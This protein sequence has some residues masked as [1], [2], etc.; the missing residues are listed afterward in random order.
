MQ[1]TLKSCKDRGGILFHRVF[2]VVSVAGGM[3]SGC[4]LLGKHQKSGSSTG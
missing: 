4:V 1:E 2:I 3:K